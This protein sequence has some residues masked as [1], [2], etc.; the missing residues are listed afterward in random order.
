MVITANGLMQNF[1]KPP[2]RSDMFLHL[3]CLC[4]VPLTPKRAR[5]CVFDLLGFWIEV[6]PVKWKMRRRDPRAKLLD[7]AG[8]VAEFYAIPK[9][10]SI[11]L[12]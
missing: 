3:V 6:V 5:P 7:D 10:L 2:Y 12:L 8:E 9:M 1:A 4:H 11:V